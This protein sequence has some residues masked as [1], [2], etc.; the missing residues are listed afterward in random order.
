ML[1]DLNKLSERL[2]FHVAACEILL[3]IFENI[4]NK[5]YE[6]VAFNGVNAS[7]KKQIFAACKSLSLRTSVKRVNPSTLSNITIYY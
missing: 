6:P 1:H 7:K 2:A 4:A 5:K 3:A